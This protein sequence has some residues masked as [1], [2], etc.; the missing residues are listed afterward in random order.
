MQRIADF[1]L[2]EP[3]SAQMKIGALVAA[4]VVLG[5]VAVASSK[6]EPAAERPAAS[7][8]PA[9]ATVSATAGATED[10]VWSQDPVSK[11]RFVAPRSLPIGPTYWT[12][13]CT[14]GKA[15][16]LGMLRRRDGNQSGEAFYGEFQAGVPRIGVIDMRKENSGGFIAGTFA[17]GDVGQGE[18]QE[19]ADAFDTAAKAARAVS[20]HFQTQQNTASASY[21]EQQATTLE[22]QIR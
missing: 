14:D 22:E 19:I 18:G 5:G 8:A 10:L 4:V 11:C 16:G 6:S 12:G 13:T 17:N 2:S 3:M 7:S 9:P 15:S 1:E 21:Y 20:S